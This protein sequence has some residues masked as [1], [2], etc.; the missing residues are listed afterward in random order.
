MTDLGKARNYD[1]A[2]QIVDRLRRYW[3]AR[4]YESPDIIVGCYKTDDTRREPIWYV[5][6]DMINGLPRR[7]KRSHK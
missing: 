2:M 6:S 3:M 5:R 4:G 7:K 1:D